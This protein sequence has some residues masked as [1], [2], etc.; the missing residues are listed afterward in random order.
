MIGVLLVT[1]GEIGAAMLSS[2]N[3]IL[4]GAVK[5]VGTLSV[6]RQDDPD[7]LVLRAPTNNQIL[8]GTVCFDGTADDSCFNNY[9]VKYSVS[10]FTTFNPVDPANPVYNSAV[11]NDPLASWSTNAGP[12]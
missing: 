4:G 8:G 5:Q 11:I 3:Q 1:H 9:T 10:P 6:W 12:G 7:D 2:A